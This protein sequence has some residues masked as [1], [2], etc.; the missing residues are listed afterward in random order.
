[1][2]ATTVGREMYSF[3]TNNKTSKHIIIT[4]SLSNVA[5]LYGAGAITGVIVAEREKKKKRGC[6][7]N[8]FF[9]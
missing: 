7:V 2:S 8:Q 9:G 6:L 5:L 1:L 4:S 3:K